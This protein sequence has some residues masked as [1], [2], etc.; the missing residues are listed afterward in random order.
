[1]SPENPLVELILEVTNACHH[2]CIHCSTVGGL[3]FPDELTQT[4]RLRVVREACELGLVE[5]RLLGGDPLF[6]LRDTMEILSLANE[7]GVE[8]ALVYTSAV[9]QNLSWL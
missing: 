9:E 7:L 2:R 4:E 3:P 8:K 6:R 5:L 1:M